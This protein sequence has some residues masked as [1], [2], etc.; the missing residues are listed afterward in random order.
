MAGAGS[1][2]SAVGKSTMLLRARIREWHETAVRGV[3]AK[4]IWGLVE[5]AIETLVW[6]V[7][8]DTL[9]QKVGRERPPSKVRLRDEVEYCPRCGREVIH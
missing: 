1:T 2:P 5:S 9:E 8:V 4:N 7:M 6:D 3:P